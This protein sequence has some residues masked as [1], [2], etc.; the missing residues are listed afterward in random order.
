M[1]VGGKGME[2]VAKPK[3]KEEDETNA[4]VQ[5]VYDVYMYP[6]WVNHP[7]QGQDRRVLTVR[8]LSALHYQFRACK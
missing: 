2:V 1:K 5:S 8:A 4:R 3:A 6:Q 7:L